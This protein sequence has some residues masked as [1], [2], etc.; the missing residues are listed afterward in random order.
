[1]PGPPPYAYG[2]GRWDGESAGG[3]T[4]GWQDWMGRKRTMWFLREG[5][6]ALLLTFCQALFW[7]GMLVSI[8]LTG[9]AGQIIAPDPSLATLPAALLMVASILLSQPISLL[10][11]RFGRRAGFSLG[12]LAGALGGVICV[13]GIFRADF[14]IFC[15][16]NVVL[17]AYHA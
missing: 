7:G 12:A 4:G 5:R 1:M 15:L 3:G 2:M 13:V 9:L 16:G 8:T 10:M 6:D 11:Q 14:N 17:G